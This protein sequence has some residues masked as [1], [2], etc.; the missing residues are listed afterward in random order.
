MNLLNSQK[1]IFT[2]AC[3]I[4]LLFSIYI[5]FLQPTPRCARLYMEDF[6]SIVEDQNISSIIDQE[7]IDNYKQE[8]SEQKSQLSLFHGQSML[9]VIWPYAVCECV[10]TNDYNVGDIISF[11]YWIEDGSWLLVGHR[12]IEKIKIDGCNFYKTKGDGNLDIDSGYRTDEDIFCE[13]P[14]ESAL[15][16]AIWKNYNLDNTAKI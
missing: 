9:P 3:I 7:H 15:S 5:I 13:I 16:V 14:Q 4:I 11:K 2:V 10:K 12:I 1:E 8:L 6:D